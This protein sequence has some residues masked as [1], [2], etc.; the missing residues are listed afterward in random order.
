MSCLGGHLRES[1]NTRTRQGRNWH[2]DFRESSGRTRRDLVKV[3]RIPS[4]RE[5]DEKQ[6][7]NSGEGKIEA[8]IGRGRSI[9]AAEQGLCNFLFHPASGGWILGKRP[10]A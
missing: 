4:R 7:R 8:Y 5:L 1:L 3:A 10:S 9:G 2:V 6:S